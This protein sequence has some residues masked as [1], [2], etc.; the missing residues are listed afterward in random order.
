METQ[1]TKAYVA[2]D[3]EKYDRETFEEMSRRELK[4]ELALLKKWRLES[5]ARREK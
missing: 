5:V 2:A 3:I 1:S 4:V